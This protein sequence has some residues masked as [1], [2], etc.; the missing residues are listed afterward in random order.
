[1]ATSNVL[2]VEPGA[3]ALVQ[4]VE[5]DRPAAVAGLRPRDVIVAYNGQ[6]VPDAYTLFDWI[7]YSRPGDRAE[8]EVIRNGVRLP[9]IVAWLGEVEYRQTGRDRDP[10][11]TAKVDPSN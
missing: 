7:T 3:G 9:P 8:L 2:G 5:A 1:V 10:L 11:K 4:R 6:S